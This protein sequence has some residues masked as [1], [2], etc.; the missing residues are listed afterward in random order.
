MVSILVSS[1]KHH[2]EIFSSG[3]NEIK[4]EF[5]S[6]GLDEHETKCALSAIWIQ[7]CRVLGG[8]VVQHLFLP[9]KMEEAPHQ[10]DTQNSLGREQSPRFCYLLYHILGTVGVQ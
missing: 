10:G 4:R 7:M 9:G 1:W 5:R 2:S 8:F 6:L 3:M